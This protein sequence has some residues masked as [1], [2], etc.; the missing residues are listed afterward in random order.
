MTGHLSAAS[1]RKLPCFGAVIGSN[2]LPVRPGA[3]GPK[4]GVRLEAL[5]GGVKISSPGSCTGVFSLIR[6]GSLGAWLDEALEELS[7]IDDESEVEGFPL[8]SER[9]RKNAE[10]VLRDLARITSIAPSVYPTSDK[11]I[12]IQF[13]ATSAVGSVL[14]LCDSE[15]SGA[16]FSYFE[17]KSQRARFDD[18]RDLPNGFAKA[19]LLRINVLQR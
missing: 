10:W 18:A 11:E 17:D 3:S 15:G 8:C 1:P 13:R 5:F 6:P 16:C 19:A 14:L 12:A 4:S 7:N 2:S 9:A